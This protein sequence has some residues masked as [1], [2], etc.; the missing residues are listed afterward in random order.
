MNAGT[1]QDLFITP[2]PTGLIRRILQIATNAND[3]VL[4][5]FAGSGTTGHATLQ[6]NKEE[7][8]NRQFILVEVEKNIAKELTAERLQR[9]SHGY[10]WKGQKSQKKKEKG[11]GGGFRYCELGVTLFDADGQIRKEVKYNDLAQH[12]YFI[13]T[14]QPLAKNAKKHF[15]LLGIHNDTAVY[16][17]Y[18]GILKDKKANGGNVLTRAILQSLSK[19]D[20]AM[21]I[22][23]TGCLLSEEK[24]REMGIT[25]RQIPYEVEAS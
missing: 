14:G 17:L 8:E 9:V 3:L 7:N 23:G 10:E 4:D 22:Y 6:M 21:I 11:L 18:N 1:S 16:L 19:H 2:K 20:G 15:P 24:L 5:S 25:F 12:V 13:E